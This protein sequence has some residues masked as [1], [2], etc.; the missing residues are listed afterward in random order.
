MARLQPYNEKA[1]W[2]YA[3]ALLHQK[4]AS[5][6]AFKRDAR[7]AVRLLQS[8]VLMQ[9]RYRKRSRALGLRYFF[10]GMAFWYAGDSLQALYS[11]QKAYRADYDRLDAVYNEYALLNEL[12]KKGEATLALRRYIRLVKSSKVDD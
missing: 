3:L 9:K 4:R 11:F 6:G 7:R 2:L 1:L 5:K 10:L 12:G 8:C